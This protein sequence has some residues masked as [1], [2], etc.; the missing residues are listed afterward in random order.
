[1]KNNLETH[2]AEGEKFLIYSFEHYQAE[3]WKVKGDIVHRWDY[4]NQTWDLDILDELNVLTKDA[5]DI[6]ECSTPRSLINYLNILGES[7]LRYDFS[8]YYSRELGIDRV[9]SNI[10]RLPVEKRG[11]FSVSNGD[12]FNQKEAVVFDISAERLRRRVSLA[13][14]DGVVE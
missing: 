13:D 11:P 8:L 6:V 9:V 12:A 3:I 1:M 2:F 7:T 14:A 4:L 5:T 10:V